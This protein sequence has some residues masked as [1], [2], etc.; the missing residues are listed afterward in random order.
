MK[1]AKKPANE[2]ERLAALERLD[3]LDTLPQRIFDDITLLAS[4]ICGTPIALISLVDAE[5]QWFKSRVGLEATQTSREVAFCSH[6]ILEPEQVMVVED[7][8]LDERFH[9]NPLVRDAPEIRFYAG[10]P[11]MTDDGFALGTVCVID[12]EAR[13]LSASQQDALRSLSRLVITLLEHDKRNRDERRLASAEARHRAEYLMAMATQSLDLKAFVDLD[14]TYRYV[15]QT[16]LDYFAM[17]REDMEGKRVVDVFGREVFDRIVKPG[18]DEAFAGRAVG[19]ESSFT[20]PK[21]GRTYVDVHY[22]PARDSSGKIMGVAVRIQDIQARKEREKLLQSTV[23]LL[24]NKTLEQQRFIDVV[25]HDLREPINTIVNFSSLLARDHA[26]DM[27]PEA[28]RYVKFVHGGGERMKVLLDDL[29]GLLRMEN[30]VI[31]HRPVD[32]NRVIAS[33]RDDLLAAI[34]RA[35][36]RLEWDLLPVVQGDASLLRVVLQNLVANGIKFSRTDVAPVLRVAAVSVGKMHEVKVTD[37]GIGIPTDQLENVFG[38]F[39]RLHSRKQ[40]EGTGLG[41]S[42]CRRIAEMHG[43]RIGVASRLGQGS[44]FSLLLPIATNINNKESLDARH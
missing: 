2:T 36:A 23:D 30:H 15:N 6:A 29:I 41:L 4:T 13:T 7:A 1:S 9:D 3:I 18:F 12:R 25:S 19:F 33:V 32:L 20:F 16:C 27:P 22:M 34:S 10:A 38:M 39:K 11:I 17:A 8:T 40:Y 21:R 26:G 5:R 14:W 37:N 24:E 35:G 43:G 28:Q 31:E 42:I 44:C